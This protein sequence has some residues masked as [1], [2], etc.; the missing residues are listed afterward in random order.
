VEAAGGRAQGGD[1]AHREVRQVAKK[2]AKKVRGFGKNAAAIA[3]RQGI[4]LKRAR[5]ILAGATR[6]ASPAAKR[7]NPRLKRV[8]GKPKA[9][10]RK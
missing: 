8:K 3:K 10:R 4:S 5:A 1:R 9:K 6:R 2:K 7:R